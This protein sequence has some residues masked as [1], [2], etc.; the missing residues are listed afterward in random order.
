MLTWQLFP[1]HLFTLQ[2]ARL[3]YAHYQQLIDTCDQEIETVIR[4]L[5]TAPEAPPDA[6]SAGADRTGEATVE[7]EAPTSPSTPEPEPFVLRLHLMRLFGTD[8]MLIPGI[9]ESTAFTL[10]AEVG[11]DL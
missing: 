1:D 10:F 6:P 4:A 8:L 2:Q 9:G 7:G 11:A 5:D 3:T